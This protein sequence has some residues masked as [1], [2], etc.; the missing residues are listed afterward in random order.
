MSARFVSAAA[1][2]VATMLFAATAVSAEPT[3]APSGPT[4][5]AGGRTDAEFARVSLFYSPGRIER[6]TNVRRVIHPS[7]GIYC[8][9]PKKIGGKAVKPSK[10]VA[11]VA[12]EWGGSNGNNL[13]AFW[14]GIS[15]PL[16]CPSARYFEVRT[17]RVTNALPELSNNVAWTMYIP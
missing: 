1:I 9:L 16:G 2:G 10:S 15:L 17:Y 11:T 12:V 8:V 5:E 14:Q 6:Q 3:N 7:T 4:P 13:L